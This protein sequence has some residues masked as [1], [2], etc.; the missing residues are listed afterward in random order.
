MTNGKVYEIGVVGMYVHE[1]AWGK[2]HSVTSDVNSYIV[3]A[4]CIHVGMAF[5]SFPKRL[6]NGGGHLQYG[7]IMLEVLNWCEVGY[8]TVDKFG[9]RFIL[10]MELD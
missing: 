9:S 10:V 3:S 1:Y 4:G 6:Y 8:I 7:L 2:G 5:E